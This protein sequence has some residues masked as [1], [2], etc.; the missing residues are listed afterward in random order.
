[1]RAILCCAA[2]LAAP[3]L[4]GE[5]RRVT[6]DNGC[7]KGIDAD[8]ELDG[9]IVCTF[10]DGKKRY[11]GTWR[12]GK[13]VGLAKTWWESGKL[14]RVER[15]EDGVRAGLVE[16]YRR[17]GSMEESCHYRGDQR[18]GVCRQ[19][20]P[21]GVLM[22]ERTYEQG[23]QTGPWVDYHRNGKVQERGTLDAQGQRH[24]R[25]ERFRDDGGPDSVVTWVH[26]KRD[27]LELDY[28]PNGK[29]RRE[30]AWK[31]DARHGLQRDFHET[32]QLQAEACHQNGATVTGTNPCTGKKGP[33]VVTRYF[34]DGKPYESVAVQDGRQ[35]GARQRFGRDGKLELS[36]SYVQ[37][38]LDGVQK[39]FKDGRLARE[40]TFR[41]GRREGPDRTYFEDGKP[42]EETVWKDDRK[43]AST[44]WWM[45]GK[46]R[47][48]EV[49][50]GDA[51]K[52]SSWHDNGQLEVEETVVGD[53]TRE[54]R[55][56]TRRQWS[57][58]GVLL[59]DSAWQGGKQHG[60][61]RL[62]FD[63]TG[64]PY[65]EEEWKDG[66]RLSRKEWD[67][68]GAVV[69]DERYNADGSRK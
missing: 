20:A 65:V 35:H 48:A 23:K 14:A 5:A 34:P 26:G 21:G 64:K 6:D 53:R 13:R 46:K 17:D 2:L 38:Q 22:W 61:R 30:T 24:G 27:G 52:R 55:E 45:N 41:A 66:V 31:G 54:R 62:F 1:M 44:T 33:E 43:V 58:D 42:S 3:A 32:G 8:N 47:R 49:L 4:A 39:H 59:E 11:E 51:W 36:E 67:E 7:N 28:H 29:V 16:E 69:K 60:L 63:K 15:F 12:H 57:E 19:Y 40:T 9:E 18:H 25:V 68:T 50:E 10:P 37:G 56:G